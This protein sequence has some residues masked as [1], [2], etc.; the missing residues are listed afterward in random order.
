LAGDDVTGSA[1]GRELADMGAAPQ[2]VEGTFA[3]MAAAMLVEAY[4]S[5][6]RLAG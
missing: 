6:L 3:V 2:E 4:G 1:I 5:R